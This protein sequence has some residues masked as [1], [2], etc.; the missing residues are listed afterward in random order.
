MV[1]P[2][3]PS[4]AA[5]LIARSIASMFMCAERAL[6]TARRSRGLSSTFAPPICT[7]TV[8]SLPMRAMTF[9]FLASFTDFLCLMLSQ[10]ECLAMAVSR[11]PGCCYFFFRRADFDDG[12]GFRAADAADFGVDEVAD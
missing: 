3:A 10:W 6:A 1:R 5:F 12:F 4:P 8:I 9:A 7:A 11:D 2:S